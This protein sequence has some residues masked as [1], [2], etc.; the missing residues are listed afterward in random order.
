MVRR[1]YC[2]KGWQLAYPDN[3]TVKCIT[4]GTFVGQYRIKRDSPMII[5]TTTNKRSGKIKEKLVFPSIDHDG[6]LHYILRSDYDSEDKSYRI[7][8]HRLFEFVFNDNDDILR[9][10]DCDHMDRNRWCNKPE[11]TR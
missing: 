2:S 8:A 4:D 6:Y 11:N 9:N 10:T 1:Y 5:K 7:S 3:D